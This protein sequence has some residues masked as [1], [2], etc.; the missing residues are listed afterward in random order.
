LPLLDPER[1]L[2]NT[3]VFF[4]TIVVMIEVLVIALTVIVLHK[5]DYLVLALMGDLFVFV[6][7]W[8]I[9]SGQVDVNDATA[10]SYMAF[11][12]IIGLIVFIAGLAAIA[13][14]DRWRAHH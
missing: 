3:I 6:F 8:L 12:H 2:M 10:F 4:F 11:Y 5:S 9:T 14:K 7:V 13:Q 1:F